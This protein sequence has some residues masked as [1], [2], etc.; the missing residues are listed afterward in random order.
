MKSLS[1][2]AVQNFEHTPHTEFMLDVIDALARHNHVSIERIEAEDKK[3]GLVWNWLNSAAKSFDVDKIMKVLKTLNLLEMQE[4]LDK[5]NIMNEAMD[6]S[7]RAARRKEQQSQKEVL[8]QIQAISLDSIT[9]KILETIPDAKW[10]PFRNGA[11]YTGKITYEANTGMAEL[12]YRNDGM[13]VTSINSGSRHQCYTEDMLWDWINR[14]GYNKEASI[15]LD[16]NPENFETLTADL[17]ANYGARIQTFRKRDKVLGRAEILARNQYDTLELWFRVDGS[18]SCN[19]GRNSVTCTK[20]SQ[21]IKWLDANANKLNATQS[22]PAVEAPAIQQKPLQISQ[23]VPKRTPA[24]K[25][26]RVKL[27]LSGLF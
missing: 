5:E 13:I 26:T 6:P 20:H 17:R 9:D 19:N 1:E 14:N 25:P 22:A 12:W 27:D 11:Y 3:Q 2:T 24:Q 23:A 4:F 15:E 7:V 16:M 10:H 21:L 8:L 18:V